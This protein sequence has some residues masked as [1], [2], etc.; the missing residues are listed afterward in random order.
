MPNSTQKSI[1]TDAVWETNSQRSTF[2]VDYCRFN[3]RT[4]FPFDHLESF[5]SHTNQLTLECQAH[6]LK[7]ISSSSIKWY[8]NGLLLDPVSSG[9][10]AAIQQHGLLQ[11]SIA[12][13]NET[14]SGEYRCDIEL[15][16]Q[17]VQSVS[18]N[19]TVKPSI[20]AP[21]PEERQKRRPNQERAT[22]EERSTREHGEKHAAP[23]ALA[24]FMKN[25]TIEEGNRAKF[26][27]S[28][29]GKVESVDWFKNNVP[30]QPELDRRYRM[31][32]TDAT[33]SLE[34]QDVVPDDSGFY[35]CTIN[36]RRNSVTSSSK[37]TVYEAYNKSRKVSL[38]YD[39]PPMSSP[40]SEFIEKGKHVHS[41]A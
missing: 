25:L 6:S 4:S 38:T 9:K 22:I 10:Y 15:P 5:A 28:V 11:L 31:T 3:N 36:G 18:H 12:N 29:I 20:A 8:K 41:S 40:L 35:T 27:C 33:V 2:E 32:T 21:I 14:D 30:L 1:V 39:R 7:Y 16:G 37:L 34:I 13:P 17:P 24:S 26:V 19:V 23:V